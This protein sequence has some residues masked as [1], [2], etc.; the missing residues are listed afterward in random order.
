[1]LPAA[2]FFV[3][4]GVAFLIIGGLF[5]LAARLGLSF[6][7]IP[8]NIRI[9]GSNFTCIFGLGISILLSIIL[10]V[11]LNLFARFFGK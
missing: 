4:L 2:R 8:G 5:Y 3:L 10:T 9:E 7:N 1:M 6:S 11:L